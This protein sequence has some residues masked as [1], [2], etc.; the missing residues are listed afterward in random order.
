MTESIKAAVV[1]TKEEKIIKIKANIAAL[2]VKLFNVEN[3]IAVVRV[4]KVVELPEVGT[5]VIFKHGRTTP[6]TEPVERIGR[7]VAV[8]APVPKE[9]GKTTP[10]QVKLSVGE[11]FEQ[12]FVVVY[13]GQ[14]VRNAVAAE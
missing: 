13:L 12:E 4:A 5:D 2:E 1:L 3:D 7:V 9:G 8:K 14:I 6:T 11:G 10:A